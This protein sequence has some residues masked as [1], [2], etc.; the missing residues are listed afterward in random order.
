MPLFTGVAMKVMTL[1]LLDQAH[2]TG[3]FS[4]GCPALRAI[5]AGEC[6]R[7]DHFVAFFGPL[8]AARVLPDASAMVPSA[9]R[10]IALTRTPSL[11][12]ECTAHLKRSMSCFGSCEV[13]FAAMTRAIRSRVRMGCLRIPRN[14]VSAS[15][16]SNPLRW[17]FV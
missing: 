16:F 14:S 1:D 13:R 8:L 17:P 4:G 9:W 6:N 3:P 5:R 7:Q 12:A 2:V 15:P 11:S 10:T